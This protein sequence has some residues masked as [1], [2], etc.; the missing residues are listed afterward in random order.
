MT[1][2][3]KII[4]WDW[5]VR[6]THWGMAL[7]IPALWWTAEEGDIERHRWLGQALL[8]LI[9]LRLIWGLI[10]S[11]PARFVRFV[12]GP[13]AIIAYLRGEA[14]PLGHNPLGALSV[15]ALL[16][17]LL[18]QLGLGLLAQ[19]E[20][21]LVAGPLNHLVSYETAEALTGWHKWLFDFIVALIAVHIGA[22]FYYMLF[23]RNDLITPMLTGRK[24]VPEETPPP[25]LASPRRTLVAIALAAAITSWIALGAPPS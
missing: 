17:I 1:D 11:E 6:L 10:G 7:L 20:Y 2:S 12:R 14:P 22:V 19:D 4:L 13:S 5:P 8:F 24:P 21:G 9:L 16:T 25:Q 3:A 23:Q 15:V 18:V